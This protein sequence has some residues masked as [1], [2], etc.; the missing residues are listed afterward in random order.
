MC[1]ISE[2]LIDNFELLTVDKLPS[3]WMGA[4]MNL[5]PCSQLCLKYG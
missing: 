2:C 1:M 3:G 5:L 4:V